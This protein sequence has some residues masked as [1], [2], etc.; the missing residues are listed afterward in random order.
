[1]TVTAPPDLPAE[2]DPLEVATSLATT[3]RSLVT[4]PVSAPSP[5]N[6]ESAAPGPAASTVTEEVAVAS[7]GASAVVT[8]AASA[9]VTVEDS[10]EA[11]ISV[12]VTTEE[13]VQVSADR[14]DVTADH[15]LAIVTSSV[16]AIAAPEVETEDGQRP[17][18]AHLITLITL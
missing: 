11:E 15:P 13:V 14:P 18:I 10:V 7:E 9:A 3:A 5:D 17:Y 4:S 6:R 1:M 8:A 2:T 16:E 12:A